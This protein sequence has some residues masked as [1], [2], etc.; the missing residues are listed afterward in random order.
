MPNIIDKCV[1]ELEWSNHPRAQHGRHI[2]GR[3][4]IAL[5]RQSWSS[6]PRCSLRGSAGHWEGNRFITDLTKPLHL[7]IYGYPSLTLDPTQRTV[8]LV[9]P[10][11]W[12]TTTNN[13]LRSTRLWF[14][15]T[16]IYAT[17][18]DYGGPAVVCRNGT[19]AATRDG[20]F[21]EEG[22]GF[23]C[24][25]SSLRMH[26]SLITPESTAYKRSIAKRLRAAFTTMDALRRSGDPNNGAF[27]PKEMEPYFKM[28]EAERVSQLWEWLEDGTPAPTT[29]A[30]A[31]LLTMGAQQWGYAHYAWRASSADAFFAKSVRVAADKLRREKFNIPL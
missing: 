10:Y 19:F 22:D 4:S 12:Y 9:N 17:A 1:K 13:V 6:S 23:V 31:C 2:Y 5:L 28:S 18:H 30:Y 20:T 25:D 29:D 11:G 8:T 3:A 15:F 7:F 14:P 21:H 24:H 26:R 16:Y 27:N